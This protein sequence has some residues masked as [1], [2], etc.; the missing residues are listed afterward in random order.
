VHPRPPR[1]NQFQIANE[2][3]SATGTPG[4]NRGN[5]R[6][7]F[8][9]NLPAPA[10]SSGYLDETNSNDSVERANALALGLSTESSALRRPQAVTYEPER[11]EAKPRVAPKSY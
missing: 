11:R 6:K 5:F 10:L 7:V 8:K 3:S 4:D 2:A 1:V 9:P